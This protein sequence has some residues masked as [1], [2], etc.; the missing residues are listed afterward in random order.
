MTLEVP[1]PLKRSK[2]TEGVVSTPNNTQKKNKITK[3]NPK[4]QTNKA[5]P[6][7]ANTKVNE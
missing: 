6:A 3:Q 7:M 5:D 1:A 4:Q 2:S